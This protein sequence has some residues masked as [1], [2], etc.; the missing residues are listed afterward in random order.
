MPR[1]L[2]RYAF[3]GDEIRVMVVM[4]NLIALSWLYFIS[5]TA[6]EESSLWVYGMSQIILYGSHFVYLRCRG[7]RDLLDALNFLNFGLFLH[8]TTAPFLLYYNLMPAFYGSLWDFQEYSKALVLTQALCVTIQIGYYLD[9]FKKPAKPLFNFRVSENTLTVFAL[10]MITMSLTA[11]MVPKWLSRSGPYLAIFNIVFNLPYFLILLKPERSRLTTSFIVY[12]G[13]LYALVFSLFGGKG[14]GSKQGVVNFIFAYIIYRNY[15]RK[16]IGLSRAWIGVILGVIVV[17]YMNYARIGGGL[18]SLRVWS[19]NPFSTN[20]ID[21]LLS[22]GVSSILTPFEAF[23]VILYNFPETIPFQNGQRLVEEMVYPL[24]PRILFSGKPEIYGIGFYW[25][26]LKG[27]LSLGEAKM[28]E[29]ISLQ[30]S[31]YMDFRVPGL[32]VCGLLIGIIHRYIYKRLVLD[33]ATR[34]SICMYG[35]ISSQVLIAARGFFWTSYPIIVFVVI[36]YLLLRLLHSRARSSWLIT[37]LE[38]KG[39]TQV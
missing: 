13:S 23:L 21:V 39:L 6:S 30:G 15:F 4:V 3:K 35:I 5:V 33:G 19:L 38:Q 18:S 24:F 7:Q 36:P 29:A 2:T 26:D 25:D 12:C 8:F 1:A 34:G 9:L 27:F 20:N 22:A 37:S 17:V 28:Y 14:I 31:F 11:G 32:L 16:R 10:T